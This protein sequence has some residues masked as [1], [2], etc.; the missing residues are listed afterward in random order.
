MPSGKNRTTATNRPPRITGHHSG[1]RAVRT[2]RAAL[3]PTAPMIAPMRLLRPPVATQ[4]TI[5]S[6]G[7]TPIW[8]GVIMPTCG[9]YKAPAR[10]P[11]AAATAKMKILYEATG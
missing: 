3:I 9:T 7:R 10:P 4:T 8:L 6:D 1:K 2:L 11:N 5:S